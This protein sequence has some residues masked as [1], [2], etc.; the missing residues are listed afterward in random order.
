MERIETSEAPAALGPYSQG[1]S[2][3]NLVFTAGQIPVNPETGTIPETIEEQAHQAFKNV[4]AVLEKGNAESV[5]NVTL[6]LKNIADFAVVNSI[7]GEYFREPYP[8]RTC[9]E[10][11]SLP[12]GALLEV[13]AIGI[14]KHRLKTA[15]ISVAVPDSRN[16][17]VLFRP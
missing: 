11:S 4:M 9:V 2:A 13:A 8:A 3:G 5:A 7:Y 14:S 10:V 15:G 6:Y 12:K 16:R 17:F 1:I